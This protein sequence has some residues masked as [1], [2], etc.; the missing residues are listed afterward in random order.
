MEDVYNPCAHTM[1]SIEAWPGTGDLYE[2][3]LEFSRND[4]LLKDGWEICAIRPTILDGEEFVYRRS[5][6]INE[7]DNR[8]I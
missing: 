1:S 7:N 4:L 2:Y 3:R 6:G 5:L 8:K